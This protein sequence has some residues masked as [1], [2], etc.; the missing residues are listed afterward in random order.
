VCARRFRQAMRKVTLY[1][2]KLNVPTGTTTPVR[3]P[4]VPEECVEWKVGTQAI[5][6]LCIK[7]CTR[8]FTII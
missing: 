3:M 5:T 2:S 6:V 8:P 1:R 7:H 4:E